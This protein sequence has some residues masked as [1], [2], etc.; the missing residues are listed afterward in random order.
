MPSETQDHDAF[1]ARIAEVTEADQRLLGLLIGGSHVNGTTDRFSDLDCVLVADDA[2]YRA[3]LD[4]RRSLAAR[5]GPL[6]HAFTGEHVGEPRLMICLYEQPVLHVDIKVVTVEMLRDRVEDPKIVWARD[7]RIRDVLGSTESHWPRQT[8]EWFEERFWIWAHYG[9]MK[10]GRGEIFEALDM[11]AFL[12]ARVFGPLLAER[13]GLRQY[14]VR[15]IETL[16]PDSV[17]LLNDLTP[18]HNRAACAKALSRAMDA[19]L[20]LTR[21]PVPANRN[22]TAE[23]AVRRYLADAVS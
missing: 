3:V 12:R 23:A 7:R 18:P 21:T 1:L 4:D 8:P 5:F 13:A 20:D 17:P 11:F 9:A 22:P 2:A 6:L 15:R 10:I 14:Q 16:I 19:Y